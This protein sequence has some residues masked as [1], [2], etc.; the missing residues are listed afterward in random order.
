MN[1]IKGYLHMPD[2]PHNSF[3]SPIHEIPRTDPVLYFQVLSV[4]SGSL[5]NTL[6]FLISN[7]WAKVFHG[8]WASESLWL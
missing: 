3:D 7:Q 2:T 6:D 8:S 4:G 1:L 5:K